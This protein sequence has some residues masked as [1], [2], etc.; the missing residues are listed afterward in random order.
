MPRDK[1]N[2]PLPVIALLA[3]AAVAGFLLSTRLPRAASIA[4][5]A[6]PD[7]GKIAAR[8]TPADFST[9]APPT[10]SAR[11]AKFSPP[12]DAIKNE[13]LLRFPNA[14]AL[15][16]FLDQAAKAG[17]RVLG[18]IPGLDAVR[19]GFDS[20]AQGDDLRSLVPD[21]ATIGFNYVASL[22]PAPDPSKPNFGGPYQA[23]GSGALAWLGVP[24]DNQTWGQG[25]TVAVLDTAVTAVPGLSQ[26]SFTSIDLTGQSGG[27]IR[28][29]TAMASIIAGNSTDAPGIAPSAQLLSIAVLNGNGTGDCFTVA[30]GIMDAVDG[31]ARVISMSLGSYGDS[32]ILQDA[33]NYALAHDVAIIAAVGNDGTGSVDYPAKYPG[34]IGV[35]AVDANGQHAL[36]ANYGPGVSIAAPGIGV[37]T[38]W[39]TNTVLDVSGTSPAVPFVSGA[40]AAILSQNPGMTVQA[41]EA[42][43]IQYANDAGAPGPDPIYGAGILS[44]D[45]VVNRNQ[46]GINDAAVAD[47][48]YGT[49]P[50]RGDTPVLAVTV[51]NRGTTSLN[52]VKLNVTVDGQPQTFYFNALGVGEVKSGIIPVNSAQLQTPGGIAVSSRVFLD[53]VHDAKSANDMKS[54]VFKTKSP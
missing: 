44:L 39:T 54:V 24:T 38:P 46:P 48:Y 15:Q 51:Q 16:A 21:S 1:W 34:V 33:V 41:A 19:I 6:I 9:P 53:G 17:A 47:V 18:V 45:R 23:F 14:A 37:Y 27:D 20:A 26:N 4:E 10:Q 3:L 22:P 52:N 2:S 43:L 30:Q 25:V 35:T 31:G 7:N 50:G 8:N 29:G 42:L 36:F 28:H 49:I 12:P 40:L 5:P 32:S 11:H 13:M